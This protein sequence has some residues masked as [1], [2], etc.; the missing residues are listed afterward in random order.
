MLPGA[1]CR[2]EGRTLNDSSL[3]VFG[4]RGAA[5]V[6]ALVLARALPG[7]QVTRTGDNYRIGVGPRASLFRKP[8]PELVVEIDTERFRGDQA[9]EER[10]NVRAE[11]LQKVRGPGLDGALGMIP[12][13]RIAVSFT[14]EDGN[15][16]L[17]PTDP[18]FRVALD[19]AA[20]TDGFL[21]D[22][23]SGR[24]VS[25]TGQSS[26]VAGP[27]HGEVVA[28][29]STARVKGRLV[30]LV[31]VAARALTEY[32]GLDV[33]EAREGIASW[34]RSVGMDSELEGDEESVLLSPPGGLDD[35]ILAACTWRIEGAAVLAWSLRLI[36]RLPPHDEA[37]DPTRVSTAL[38]FP[39]APATQAMLRSVTRRQMP[40]IDREAEYHN[41]IYWRLCRFLA[42]GQA[43]D[44]GAPVTSASGA[45]VRF[46]ALTLVGGDLGIGGVAIAEADPDDV[47]LA[48]TLVEER[49]T[50]LHWLRDG[51]LY[52]DIRL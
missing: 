47:Q 31:A 5:D 51:G 25:S 16:P 42:T 27:T 26:L 19:I 32:D 30:A 7:S 45:P 4:R 6:I 39:D 44:L 14:P 37:M 11:L 36:D 24:L 22:R 17:R 40:A 20:R 18:A 21:L 49:L 48:V 38:R 28:D 2:T 29:P 43:L 3:T 50:A 12:G 52:S 34:V 13:L 35:S 41:A 10:G 33:E 23:A 8:K 9:D 15:G 46:D 1:G